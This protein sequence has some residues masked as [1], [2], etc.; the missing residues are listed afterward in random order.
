MESAPAPRSSRAAS[1]AVLIPF[2]IREAMTVADAA[3]LAG[4][5]TV[6]RADMGGGT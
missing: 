1:R 3:K 5:T 2:D 6:N 4:C